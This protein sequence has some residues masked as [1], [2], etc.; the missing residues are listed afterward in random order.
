MV[1]SALVATKIA[2]VRDATSRIA[3]VL[4]TSADVFVADRTAR[5]VVTLNLFVAIQ[6]CLDLAAH[7]L[8]D[9]GWDVPAT[10]AEMFG[11]LADHGVI[12]DDLARR[13]AGAAGFRSLL[14]H[15]YGA[16]DARR[17]HDLATSG[18]RDLDAFCATLAARVRE[19]S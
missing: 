17:I 13:L 14:A 9:A 7:W 12:P 5:E 15:Q 11:A 10:Y 19:G 3:A 18:L 4:P 6:A 2:A 1:D 16:L 8:A